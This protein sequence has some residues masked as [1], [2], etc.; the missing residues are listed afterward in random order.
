MQSLLEEAASQQ[1]IVLQASQLLNCCAATNDVFRGSPEEVE[2][3]RVL[4]LASE[5][6]MKVVITLRCQ[7]IGGGKKFLKILI[8]GGGVK[9]NGGWELSENFNKRWGQNKI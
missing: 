2:A 6:G 3:E 8:N 9:I 7:I 1:N 4:L 5:L